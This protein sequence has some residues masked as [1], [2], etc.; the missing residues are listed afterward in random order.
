MVVAVGWSSGDKELGGGGWV[1]QLGQGD[2]DDN[3]I[4]MSK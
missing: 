3:I 2:D 4:F 1:E